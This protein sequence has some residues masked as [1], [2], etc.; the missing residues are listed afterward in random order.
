MQRAGESWQQAW[1]G[2]WEHSEH[3]ERLGRAFVAE[4]RISTPF[5]LAYSPSAL[6]SETEG[7]L[8]EDHLLQR[9]LLAMLELSALQVPLVTVTEA[10]PSHQQGSLVPCAW[11]L[12]KM[13]SID[14]T[15]SDS[16]LRP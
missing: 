11:S 9:Y 5:E 13:L 6:Q 10:Y 1:P 4:A 15:G 16:S 3:W 8:R 7:H 14:E 2:P 12:R